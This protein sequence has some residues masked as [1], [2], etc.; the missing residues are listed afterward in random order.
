MFDEMLNTPM[1]RLLYTYI[2]F[3]ISIKLHELYVIVF[4][5]IFSEKRKN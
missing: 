5:F 3:A 2:T 4:I 1:K